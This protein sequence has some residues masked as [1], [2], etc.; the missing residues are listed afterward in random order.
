MVAAWQKTGR[1]NLAPL[2]QRKKKE[3]LTIEESSTTKEAVDR[4][5]G[6][7]T[8]EAQANLCATCIMKNIQITEQKITQSF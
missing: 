4:A 7:A 8:V 5:E 2:C 1:R 3:P 6:E